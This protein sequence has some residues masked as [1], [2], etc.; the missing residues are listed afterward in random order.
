MLLYDNF[1][2]HG[3]FIGQA[4]SEGIEVKWKVKHPTP[5]NPVLYD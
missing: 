4:I 1:R 3:E 5:T 2:V